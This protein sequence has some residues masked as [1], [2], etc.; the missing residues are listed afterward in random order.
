MDNKIKIAIVGCGNCASSLIQGLSFY[1][2]LDMKENIYGL[3]NPILGGYKISDIRIVA[4]FDVDKRKVGKDL[5]NAILSEP[6]N[7]KIFCPIQMKLGSDYLHVLKGPVMDGVAEHMKYFFQVDE[8]QTTLT[9]EQII[10]ILK[11]RETEIIIN[12]VPVGSQELTE[13]WAQMAID[14]KC[15]FINAIPQFIA[16][17][18]KWANKFKEANLPIIGDDCKSQIGATYLHRT[19]IQMIIDRGGKINNTRQ[20]NYGGNTDFLNMLD[21]NRLKSKKISKTEAVQ[22]VLG[23]QRLSEEN[24]HIGPSDFIPNL[25]DNKIC[26][27]NINFEIFGNI[28]CTIDCKLSVEDSPNSSGCVIDCIRLAKIA[29]DRKIGGPLIGPSAYYMKHPIR[30][31]DDNIARQMVEEFI[32]E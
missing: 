15:A 17:D 5:I 28:P 4:G 7:T 30:Q 3:M 12:Y 31:Y 27:I 10:S 21:R 13:F 24:I 1:D 18:P 20:L 16:S 6:N 14:A 26:D 32:K 19:L 8:E 2:N 23:E 22:S 11:Q 9:K 29:L 25:K